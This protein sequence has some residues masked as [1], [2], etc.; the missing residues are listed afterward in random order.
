MAELEAHTT[1]GLEWVAANNGDGGAAEANMLMLS[2]WN[3][4]DEGHWIEPA[5]DKYGG[6]EKLDAIKRAI[7]KQ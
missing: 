1:A 4:H 3:E 6:T 7:D 5:L 2:A